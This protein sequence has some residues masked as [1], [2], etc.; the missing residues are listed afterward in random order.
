MELVRGE[1][2]GRGAIKRQV[3]RTALLGVTP[4]TVALL[5]KSLTREAALSGAAL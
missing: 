2:S 3:T 4:T 5:Q 1:L